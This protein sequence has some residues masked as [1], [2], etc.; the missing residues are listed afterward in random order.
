MSNAKRVSDLITGQEVVPVVVIEDQQQAQGLA[1]ALLAGGITVIEITL[2]NSYGVSAIEYI[3]KNY[4]DMVVLAGTVTSSDQ[5]R[6]VVKAGVDGII[7]PGIT[8]ALLETAKELD[9]AYLPGVATGSEILLGM[10]YGLTEFKLFP[11]TV[12]GGIGAL[13]AYSGPFGH[14]RFCPTG[15][16]SESNVKDFLALPNVMCVGGSWIAPSSLVRE[17]NWAEITRLSKAARA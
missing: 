1:E 8:R 12:V 11:A 9:V 6:D 7:S 4:P 2:R 3:K 13:K 14:I 16:V 15:G 17:G 5:L 10:E